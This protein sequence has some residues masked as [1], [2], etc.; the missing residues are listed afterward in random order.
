MKLF[1]ISIL[2]CTVGCATNE[3]KMIE[4]LLTEDEAEMAAIY[5]H[6]P[7]LLEAA[8]ELAKKSDD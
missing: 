5:K 4:K 6:N 7:F 2:F 1:L 3:T 8:R